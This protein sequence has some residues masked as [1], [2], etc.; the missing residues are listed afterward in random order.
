MSHRNRANAGL[1]KAA[2]IHTTDPAALAAYAQGL[3]P[4]VTKLRALAEDAIMPRGTRVHSRAFL[5]DG[6][7]RTLREIDVRLNVADDPEHGDP[8]GSGGAGPIA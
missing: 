3:R 5:R 8:A 7:L 6:I 2:A 1:R 4:A